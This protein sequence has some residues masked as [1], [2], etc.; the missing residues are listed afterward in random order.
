[1]S[2]ANAGPGKRAPAP[3]VVIGVAA[4]ALLATN[5]SPQTRAAPFVPIAVSLDAGRESP[6]AADLDAIRR[7]GFNSLVVR[8]AWRTAEP[9]AGGYALDALDRR[10]ADAA[11][12]QL[13]AIVRIDTD[14][15]PGWLESRFPD[16][17]VLSAR[18][19]PVTANGQRRF[20]L[21]HPGVNAAALSFINTVVTR[22]AAQP[23]VYAYDFAAEPELSA[24]GSTAAV[25]YCAHTSNRFRAFLR[26]MYGSLE[27]L[28]AAWSRRL[29]AWEDVNPPAS[30]A[31]RPGT[32]GA[33]WQTFSALRLE[34]QLRAKAGATATR[35]ARLVFDQ[36]RVPA[37]LSAGAWPADAADDW[38]M[39]RVVDRASAVIDPR[40]SGQAPWTGVQVGFALDG[41]RSAARDRGWWAGAIRAHVQRRAERGAAAAA[42]DLRLWGWTA[43]ARGARGID[44]EDLE[45]AS[46]AG[47]AAA[48]ELAGNL[49]RNA[50]LFAP[51]QPRSSRVAIVY[52][53]HVHAGGAVRESMLG[54][55]RAMFERNVQAD[56]IHWNEILAGYASE[57]A[58]L[59]VPDDAPRPPPVDA[60]L[61]AF[62]ASGGVIVRGLR[63]ARSMGITGGR[64]LPGAVRPDIR[65]DGAHGLVEARVLESADAMVVIGLNH[66]DAPHK[67]TLEFA[68]DMPEAIWQNMESGAAVNFVAGP[69]GPLYTHTF[70]PR[71]VLVL[72]IR[73]ALR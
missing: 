26:Q 16:G 30:E 39:A 64:D 35:G 5:G 63:Q 7:L 52:P 23:A 4:F 17:R 18:G 65:I 59:F 57:Y 27:A 61:G 73:K 40:P 20:C 45:G 44:Y 25:C 21:D 62:T 37:V 42:S 54:F 19:L 31:A 9:R 49:T 32:A 12:A 69:E 14:D 2:D 43:I 24:A 48:G 29:A 46:D 60:A 38:L 53:P 66:S 70:A 55:Y 58:V 51:L 13:R 6:W 50:A 47:A 15:A 67:V 28:N 36:P 10:L 3:G 8:V 22:T 1:M 56:F 33:D 41:I 72:M 68:P 34:E 71:D 11:R